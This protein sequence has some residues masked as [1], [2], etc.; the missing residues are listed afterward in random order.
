MAI[1]A[2][3]IAVAAL[4]ADAMAGVDA[5]QR[6]WGT[7]AHVWVATHDLEMGEPLTVEVRE[8]PA[9]VRPPGAI[10]DPRDAVARHTIGRGEIVTTVDVVDLDGSF[11]PPDWLVA[12]VR[13][14]LP[15]GA[16]TGERVVVVSDGF[17][18]APEGVVV[19]SVDDVTLVAVPPDA[20]PLL[21]AASDTTR[22][23]L[24][25]SP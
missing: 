3:A 4:V 11:A 18:V 17:V 19:G 10:D 16:T 25:R 21:P 2:I 20:A 13:E 14:S 12:P 22:V 8:I 9:A 6:A 7:T 23:A 15:S 1:A 5:A 24:L